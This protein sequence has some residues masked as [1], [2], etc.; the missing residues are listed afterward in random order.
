MRAD[1]MAVTFPDGFA[2]ADALVLID[3]LRSDPMRFD[4]AAFRPLAEKL[5]FFEALPEARV[6][7]LSQVRFEASIEV[8]L[9][10][11]EPARGVSV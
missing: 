6:A 9:V 10:C 7:E 5:K 4:A 8:R 2:R 1:E 11:L 3:G